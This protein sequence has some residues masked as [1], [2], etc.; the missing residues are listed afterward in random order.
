MKKWMYRVGILALGLVLLMGLFVPFNFAKSAQDE[1]KE[2]IIV[3]ITGQVKMLRG[4]WWSFWNWKDVRIGQQLFAGD[5]LQVGSNGVLELHFYNGT[6]V[7]VLANTTVVIGE[8]AL[9]ATGA[10]TEGRSSSI[11][12]KDG[13]VWVK[14]EKAV[15][16]MLKFKVETP[17]VVAGVRG[18]TFIVK[19]KAGMTSVM[20]DSGLV[21]VK[22]RKSGELVE[23]NG[24]F[25]TEV[26]GRQKPG[27]PVQA[28]ESNRSK[29]KDWSDKV[30][31]GDRTPEQSK[32]SKESKDQKDK[33][34]E[35]KAKEDKDG[36]ENA[37]K[38]NSADQG[39]DGATGN[40]ESKPNPGKD[41]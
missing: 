14:V 29:V 35:K 9:T 34:D 18:T 26:Y 1:Q 38:G 3:G 30:A 17:N 12:V 7:R 16:K 41:R 23:V 8:S 6:D 10:G 28:N 37:D 33:Q 13:E 31:N 24:G 19:A 21:E 15:T 4:P 2:A 5:R 39:N 40:G 11:F 22:Q 32:D 27:K 36:K 20:V 25:Q